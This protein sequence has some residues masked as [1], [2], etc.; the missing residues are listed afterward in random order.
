MHIY[1]H[2]FTNYVHTFTHL[3]TH[4]HYMHAMHVKENK[5]LLIHMAHLGCH[6][7]S[8]LTQ[9]H[10]YLDAQPHMY[11]KTQTR[12]YTISMCIHT[13]SYVHT[14]CTYVEYACTNTHIRK[15]QQTLI[16]SHAYLDYHLQLHKS[17]H[18][19]MQ[20]YSNTCRHINT[21]TCICT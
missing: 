12:I 7:Q 2:I 18:V 16:D 11:L 14:F 20:M 21:L 13:H 3:Y 15:I 10:T 8:Q 5:R 6:T 1:K 19:Y 17:T 4:I 9:N